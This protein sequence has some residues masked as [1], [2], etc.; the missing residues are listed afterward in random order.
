MFFIANPKLSLSFNTS[1]AA[2]GWQRDGGEVREDVVVELH[3]WQKD[4]GVRRW[5]VMKVCRSEKSGK[6]VNR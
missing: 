3:L 5:K 1:F 6:C 4:V 2:L